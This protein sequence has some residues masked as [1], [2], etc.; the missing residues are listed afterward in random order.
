MLLGMAFAIV[1][2]LIPARQ[3]SLVRIVANTLTA[4]LFMASVAIFG[5]AF[6]S[7]GYGPPNEAIVVIIVAATAIGCVLGL[8]VFLIRWCY[9]KAA[10]VKSGN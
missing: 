7:R 5:I 10:P 8:I 4:S 1:M 6:M 9:A 3:V 2:F